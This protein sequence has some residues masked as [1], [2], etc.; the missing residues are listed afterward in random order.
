MNPNYLE[1][2]RELHA[3]AQLDAQI[4]PDAIVTAKA[5]EHAISALIALHG[6]DD[7]VQRLDDEECVGLFAA[8]MKTN[9]A[10]RRSKDAAEQPGHIPT[11][12]RS[13]SRMLMAHLAT[14]DPI[15]VANICCALWNRNEK[16]LVPEF[17]LTDDKDQHHDTR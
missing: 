4:H 8:A 2:L 7:E 14:G 11:D 16:I 9:M 12:Q 13:L 6:P 1:A 15:A 10:I 3:G 5:L 17:R